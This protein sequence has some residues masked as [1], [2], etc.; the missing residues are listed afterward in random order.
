M[1]I[2]VSPWNVPNKITLGN[3][4]KWLIANWYSETKNTIEWDVLGL[5]LDGFIGSPISIPYGLNSGTLV[6]IQG[7]M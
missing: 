3:N 4:K 7:C 5:K 2:S 1:I 6:Y